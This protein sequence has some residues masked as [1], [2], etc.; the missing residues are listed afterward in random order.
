ME[1][2]QPEAQPEVHLEAQLAEEKQKEQAAR[3]FNETVCRAMPD[4]WT[5]WW[6]KNYGYPNDWIDASP[7]AKAAQQAL[8]GF[9]Q[10]IGNWSYDVFKA[11]GSSVTVPSAPQ[12]APNN[13]P[14]QQEM[15]EIPK[16]EPAEDTPE[17]DEEIQ[18]Q[19]DEN[20]EAEA[21][22]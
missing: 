4:T 2:E 3:E 11:L 16:K 9:F 18:V 21:A 15:Q 22:E 8:D 17:N 13:I 14:P 7:K 12:A 19:A 6:E 5:E 20:G 10:G 1:V